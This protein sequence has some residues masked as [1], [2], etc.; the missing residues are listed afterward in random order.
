MWAGCNQDVASNVNKLDAYAVVLGR[1]RVFF[2]LGLAPSRSFL[3]LWYDLVNK[4][5]TRIIGLAIFNS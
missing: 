1:S 4:K 5:A 2:T 3:V